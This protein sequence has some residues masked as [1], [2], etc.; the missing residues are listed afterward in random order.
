[1][2]TDTLTTALSSTLSNTR[3]MQSARILTRYTLNIRASVV[4]VTTQY[5]LVFSTELSAAV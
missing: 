1:M 3:L 4:Q 5:L 2:D